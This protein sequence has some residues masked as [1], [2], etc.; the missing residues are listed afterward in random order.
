MPCSPPETRSWPSSTLW[1]TAP[2]PF[3]GQTSWSSTWTSTWAPGPIIRPASSA[4]SGNGSWNRSV[5]GRRTTSTGSPIP[6]PSAIAMPGC[7]GPIPSICAVSVSGR[8]A[9]WPST[10]LPVADFDDPLVVKVVELEAACRRQQV[11]EGHFASIDDVP[12]QAL[13]VTIPALLGAATVLAIVPEARKA[14]PVGRALTGPVSTACPASILRTQATCGSVPRHR[15][16]RRPRVGVRTGH[17]DHAGP[18]RTGGP[19]GRMRV[20]EHTVVGAVVGGRPHRSRPRLRGPRARDRP[21]WPGPGSP[22]PS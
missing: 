10:T 1:S 20:G 22:I 12:A 17:P 7:C 6:G 9:I 14:G 11:N 16:G 8:T 13:T 3:P 19:G 5:P 21:W 4:G 2:M 15:F 18:V